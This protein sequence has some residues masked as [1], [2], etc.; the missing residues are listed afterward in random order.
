MQA[1]TGWKKQ[2]GCRV[3]IELW[4]RP[5]RKFVDTTRD[6]VWISEETDE[7]GQPLFMRIP[8][9][10]KTKYE[11]GKG[12]QVG[13]YHYS[14]VEQLTSRCIDEEKKIYQEN[15]GHTVIEIEERFPCFDSYDF[16]YENR[17][18]HWIYFVAD[19]KLNC[20]YYEDESKFIEVT[21]DVE[22]LRKE[23]WKEMKACG[24]LDESG[25]LQF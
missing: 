21:E 13:E 19:N 4:E 10:R 5:S 9:E 22:S 1:I 11:Q 3:K 24:F 25:I 12:F 2:G 23:S 16:M 18:Y 17:Y 14:S 20:V 8:E 6:V 7:K 15:Y